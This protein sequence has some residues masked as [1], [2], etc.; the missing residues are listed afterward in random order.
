MS[1]KNRILETAPGYLLWS[2]ILND[3]K[4]QAIKNILPDQEKLCVLDLGCGPGSN[5]HLFINCKYTGVDI[6]QQY[7]ERAKIVYPQLTF[8]IQDITNSELPSI[9]FNLILVNSLLHHLRDKEIERLLLQI[10]TGILKGKGWIIISEPLKAHR[11]K[12]LRRILER[13]DRGNYFRTYNEYLKLFEPYFVLE[14]KEIY[15]LKLFGVTGWQ[16]L[17]MCLIKK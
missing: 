3:R 6:N 5:A 10:Y 14:K 9:S 1:L 17:T 12:L 2:S 8:L 13:L 7:I 4:I 11:D 15:P 16:M